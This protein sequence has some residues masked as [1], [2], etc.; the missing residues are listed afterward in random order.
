MPVAEGVDIKD[1][2]VARCHKEVLRV[3]KEHMPRI[4]V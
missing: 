1:V 3:G 4:E 2:S